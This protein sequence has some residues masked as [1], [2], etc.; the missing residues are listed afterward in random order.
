MKYSRDH[1]K[2]RA[3][4]ISDGMPLDHIFE[5]ADVCRIGRDYF[6]RKAVE[7]RCRELML[8]TAMGGLDACHLFLIDILCPRED[9]FRR[10]K[11]P[12]RHGQ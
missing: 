5:S 7:Q 11:E 4:W 10:K 9:D 3:E 8:L 2:R 12:A 6:D 1:D